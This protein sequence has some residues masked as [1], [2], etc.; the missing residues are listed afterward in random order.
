MVVKLAIV[1]TLVLALAACGG[2]AGKGGKVPPPT[3]AGYAAAAN[4]VCRNTNTQS[5]RI[6]GLQKLKPPPAEHDLVVRWLNAERWALDAFDEI[7]QP[8]KEGGDPRVGLAVAEGKIAGYARRLG[9]TACTGMP[10]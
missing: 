9:A 5:A 3:R 2:N 4:R 1:G 7:A 6:S 8:K 10:S